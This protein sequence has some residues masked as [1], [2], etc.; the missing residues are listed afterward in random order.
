M[1]TWLARI[2]VRIGP[3][4][5]WYTFIFLNR[6]V[7]QRRSQVKCHESEYNLKLLDSL[8]NHVSI[9]KKPLQGHIRHVDVP[10]IGEW[11]KSHVVPHKPI[12]LVHPG[13]GGSALN[14]TQAQYA[15]I[16]QRLIEYGIFIVITS[17]FDDRSFV[18][19]I[20]ESLPM[21]GYCLYQ[22]EKNDSILS[23]AH[24]MR[25]ADVV[26][27]PSTGPLHLAAA[28]NKPV[29]S[30]FSSIVVQSAERWGPLSLDA[31]IFV[32]QVHCGQQFYCIKER[33][34]AF[35]CM[36]KISLS[37]VIDYIV[38]KSFAQ[39]KIV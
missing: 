10:E 21:H 9:D 17:G 28:L 30:F 23:L 31:K 27:A 3:L 35:Y 18:T 14:L 37:A 6:G 11:V 12:V 32:P 15:Q 7:R 16:I 29:V 5:R 8:K 24:L 25:V 1:A 22:A 36:E 39:A 2:P 33:C 20:V 26:V 13:M 4:N 19:P 34:P 38:E